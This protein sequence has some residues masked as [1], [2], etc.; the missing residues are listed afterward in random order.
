[1]ETILFYLSTV[2]R[3]YIALALGTA[4]MLAVMLYCSKACRLPVGKTVFATVLLTLAGVLGTKL[5]VYIENGDWVGV[6]FYGA[7]LFVPILFV[8]V[9]LLLRTPYGRLMDLCAVG[10]CA[11]LVVMKAKCSYDGC[12]Y[13]RVLKEMGDGLLLR[14]PSQTV[15]MLNGAV[16]LVLLVRMLKKG[17]RPGQIYGWFLL[18]YGAT[19]FVLNSFRGDLKPLVWII[20]PGHFWSLV[21]MAAGGIW[22]AVIK[23]VSEGKGIEHSARETIS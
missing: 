2:N 20:P 19:R 7:V 5:M 21:A 1:M 3:L 13:G 15:E 6:S 17:D 16:L 10:E 9:A 18:L 22:I 23:K 4:L 12:C 14:F 11:M 8:P